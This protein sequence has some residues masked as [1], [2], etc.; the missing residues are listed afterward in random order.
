MANES[1]QIRELLGKDADDLL[2]YQAKGFN[3][4]TLHLPG[5]TL[6]IESCR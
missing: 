4:S 6:L 2:S 3:K 1:K 5:Q